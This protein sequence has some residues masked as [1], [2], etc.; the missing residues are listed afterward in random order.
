MKWGHSATQD[1]YS[2]QPAADR[3]DIRGTR[4]FRC[5]QVRRLKVLWT[6]LRETISIYRRT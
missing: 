1:R 5:H 2:R 3:A 6:P 4:A